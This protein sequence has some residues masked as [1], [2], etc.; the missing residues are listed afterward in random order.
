MEA[1]TLLLVEDDATSAAFLAEALTALPALVEVAGS[2]AQ[3][4][5]LASAS[6]HSL[7]LVDAHLP[8]GDG[9]DCLRALRALRDT[10]ALA[11][12]AGAPRGQ[13]DALCAAGFLEVLMKPVSI[14]LLHA[15]VRRLLGQADGRAARHVASARD[16]KL[17]TWEQQRA[18]AAI[19]GN[20]ES[21]AKLRRLFLDELPGQR[22]QLHVAHARADAGAAS[23]LLHK[24]RAS[25][26]FVG[27]ARL[28]AAVEVLARSPLD[29]GALREFGFATEDTLASGDQPAVNQP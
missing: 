9:L 18:L 8:D 20:A 10:P 2:I 24:L 4:R 25:C 29:A 1:P 26:G 28:A 13:L 21:L 5:V 22:E 23:A 11:I 27:A 16:G 19:G 3:A 12:T 15:T 6:T 7:W 14:A 17:P